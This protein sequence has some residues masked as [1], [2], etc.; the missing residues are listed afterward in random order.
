MM[1]LRQGHSY[2]WYL[3]A[4]TMHSSLQNN[5]TLHS[6]Q[7]T[8]LVNLKHKAMLHSVQGTALLNLT[9]KAM[10]HSMQDTALVNLKEG[11]HFRKTFLLQ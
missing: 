8:A 10:L 3:L 1:T 4:R 6:M 9:H 5:A 7:G 11:S 2:L